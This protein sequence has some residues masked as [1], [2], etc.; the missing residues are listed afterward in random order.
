MTLAKAI[1]AYRDAKAHTDRMW[2]LRRE[3]PH[4]IIA[5]A[6]AEDSRAFGKLLEAWSGEDWP[7]GV[8]Q[9]TA[10]ELE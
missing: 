5:K 7:A 2:K 9:L 4:D 3:L 1:T 10:E 6:F 8:P